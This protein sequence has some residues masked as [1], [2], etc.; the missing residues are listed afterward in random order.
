[1]GEQATVHEVVTVPLHCLT[2]FSDHTQQAFPSPLFDQESTTVPLPPQQPSLALPPPASAVAPKSA[3]LATTAAAD[4]YG[5]LEFDAIH[6]STQ[7]FNDLAGNGAIA[8]DNHAA[9]HQT[10]TFGVRNSRIGFKMKGPDSEDIRTSAIVEMDFFGNQP[11][12]IAEA[13]LFVNPGFR[14]RHF[15][16]KLETPIVDIM[17]GQYWQLF[18][19]QSMFHPNTVEIQGMP[20]QVYSRSPQIRVSRTI[21][22]DDINIEVAV[23]AVRPARRDSSTPDGQAGLRL[24][25]NQWKGLHTAGSTGTAIDGL[26]VGVSGVYRHVEVA[27]LSASP[28]ATSLRGASGCPP[29]SRR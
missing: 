27:E 24:V 28:T 13:A 29:T 1:L 21:K 12:G 8:R 23:A 5:F 9:S 3:G 15:A 16:L 11:S 4:L 7:S 20:G 18:G 19:W 22:T 26:S 25:L 6:D 10:T 17:F 2:I 14:I